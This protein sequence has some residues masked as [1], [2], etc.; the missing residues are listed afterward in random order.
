[1]KTHFIKVCLAVSLILLGF[2]NASCKKEKSESSVTTNTKSDQQLVNHINSFLTSAKSVKEGKYYKSGETMLLDSALYY[3]VATLN[4]KYGFINQKFH[5]FKDDTIMVNIPY[6]N[7]EGET[8]LL[9]ALIGYN[10]S[11]EKIKQKYLEKPETIKNL[12][13]CVVQNTGLTDDLD[14][15]KV[16]IIAQ[17]GL[18]LPVTPNQE[19]GYWWSRGGGDCE[20]IGQYG[21]PNYLESFYY[22]MYYSTC[23]NARIFFT[24][25]DTHTFGDPALHS[26][27]NGIPNDNF[28]DYLIYFAASNIGP[29]L[30]QDMKCIGSVDY[31][32][33][34]N[35]TEIEF[36]HQGLQKVIT[37]TLN[38][39]DRQFINSTIESVFKS[40]PI[41]NI[42]TLRHAPKLKYGKIHFICDPIAIYP[43][44]LAE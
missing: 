25:V 33:W 28:C 43:V 2:A 40:D 9:D 18:G 26:N 42:V 34:A 27:P 41:T 20:Q 30:T 21:A 8:Y 3:I 1:M 36:Y 32:P 11:V 16:R 23:P 39:I 5:E 22:G 24:D 10:I 19:V 6:L 7:G 17:I 35:I 12:V 15:V 4:Y 29:G 31:V 44:P 13:C 38:I 37:D 14:S